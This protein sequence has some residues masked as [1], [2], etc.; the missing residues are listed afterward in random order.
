MA[1]GASIDDIVA[2]Y[3]RLTREDVTAAVQYAAECL[4]GDSRIEL[5]LSH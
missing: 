3:P 1:G 2:A 5:E 4:R